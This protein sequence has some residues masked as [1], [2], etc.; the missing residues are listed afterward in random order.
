MK[1]MIKQKG[2]LKKLRNSKNAERRNHILMVWSLLTILFFPGCTH[3]PFGD[4][5]PADTRKIREAAY[6]GYIDRI[7]SCNKAFDGEI[8][9]EWAHPGSSFKAAGFFRTMIPSSVFVSILN[10]LDQPL[11]VATVTDGQYQ[12]VNT[13]KRTYFAGSLKTYGLLND[14]PV[15][16]L[17]G[18]WGCWLAGRPSA[19]AEVEQI[20]QD[21]AERGTWFAL[22]DPATGDITEYLLVDLT[23]DTM[24]ERIIVNDDGNIEATITY[25][26]WQE[27]DRCRQPEEIEIT[28]LDFGA[29]ALIRLSDI[30]GATLTRKDF[31]I[32]VPPHYLRQYTP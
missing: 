22:T 13:G 21:P 3:K 14:I 32:P 9:I 26:A 15:A 16:F 1:T 7:A 19:E 5:I 12:A 11:L 29:S 2:F 4:P 30:H 24:R 6:H 27:R 23:T 25:T 18:K 31:T 10:P 20:Y 28:G 8:R 17:S